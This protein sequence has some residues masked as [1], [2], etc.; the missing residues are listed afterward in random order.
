MLGWEGSRGINIDNMSPNLWE[1][2]HPEYPA[3]W[4]ANVPS[5]VHEYE[6]RHQEGAHV[7]KWI[8]AHL[9]AENGSP[10]VVIITDKC[11][12]RCATCCTVF[13]PPC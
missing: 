7:V 1:F 8:L 6:V 4:I 3:N 11:T 9:S 10:R 2:G 13:R 5:K 12:L